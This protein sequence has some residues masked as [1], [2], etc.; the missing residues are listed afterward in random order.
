MFTNCFFFKVIYMLKKGNSSQVLRKITTF[1][2]P[3]E[4]IPWR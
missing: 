2:N 4:S 1:P 3:G